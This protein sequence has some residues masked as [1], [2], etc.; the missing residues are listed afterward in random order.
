MGTKREVVISVH[1]ADDPHQMGRYQIIG[2][3]ADAS[4]TLSI[5]GMR[6]ITLWVVKLLPNA[7]EDRIM[8]KI[9]VIVRTTWWN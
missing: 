6:L 9:E 4:A 7:V 2:V 5:T 3:R 8:V 1:S